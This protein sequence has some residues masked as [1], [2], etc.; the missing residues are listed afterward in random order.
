MTRTQRRGGDVSAP[1]DGFTVG[2]TADRRL[3]EQVTLLE[4]R[5]AL[6]VRAPTMRT[7]P[8]TEDSDVRAATDACLAAPIDVVIVTTG[9][10]LS[11]WLDYASAR[12]VRSRLVERL[13]GARV[14][15]RGP[16]AR[17]AVRAAG[18][19]EAWTPASETSAEIRDHL[20]SR[21]VRGQ[22]IAVQLHGE[23]LPELVG[24]LR[25]AGATVVEVPVYRWELPADVSAARR[26]AG[27]IADR[28]IDAV[29]FTSA[30]AVRGLLR[31][32]AEGER[33]DAVLGAFRSDVVAACVGPVTARPFDEQGVSTAQP[34]RAR[35]KALVEMLAADLPA[36]RPRG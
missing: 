13:A 3:Q 4:R 32:A 29:T 19:P 36:R 2:V 33:T 17:G 10:G 8:S 30:P 5:G 16:K 24:E 23:P 35:T 15:A 14:L 31:V 6:V 20:L 34:H 1:L 11:G 25:R 22:R 26:L 27:R 12:D 21:G 18:L 28:Q 9:V 7:V